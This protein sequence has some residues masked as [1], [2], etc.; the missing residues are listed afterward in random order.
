[1]KNFGSK[2]KKCYNFEKIMHFAL[3][4]KEVNSYNKLK[5]EKKMLINKF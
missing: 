5:E 1:M 3:I 4:D 2:I